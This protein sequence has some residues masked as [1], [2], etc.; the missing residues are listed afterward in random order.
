[1]TDT[2]R[3]DLE[4]RLLTAELKHGRECDGRPSTE[5][6]GNDPLLQ[7][8]IREHPEMAVKFWNPQS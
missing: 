7:A 2:D 1:M 8:L 5:D 6:A 4:R 3:T